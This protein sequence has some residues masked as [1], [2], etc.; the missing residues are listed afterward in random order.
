MLRGAAKFGEGQKRGSPAL[1]IT[2]CFMPVEA[3]IRRMELRILL[4][5]L[6]HHGFIGGRGDISA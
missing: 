6:P 2:F 3:Q 5:R 4:S 1:D